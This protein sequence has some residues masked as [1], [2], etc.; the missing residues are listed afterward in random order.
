MNM[1]NGTRIHPINEPTF[2]DVESSVN[3]TLKQSMTIAN[4]GMWHF[5]VMHSSWLS[6]LNLDKSNFLSVE[7]MQVTVSVSDSIM[8]NGNAALK[9]FRHIIITKNIS[10]KY[11]I[12]LYVYLDQHRPILSDDI[13]RVRLH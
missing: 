1:E 4:N 7:V 13:V 10:D 2:I 5:Q 3:V 11:S 12:D 6:N 9:V 8:F